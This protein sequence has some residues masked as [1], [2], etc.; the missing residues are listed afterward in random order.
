ME[1]HYCRQK[2]EKEY[3][4]LI[5]TSFKN[6]YKIFKQYISDNGIPSNET[7]SY[8]TF[9]KITHSL[10]IRLYEPKKDQC[11]LCFSF[12]NNN[13]T[14]EI[15]GSHIENKNKARKEKDDDKKRAERNEINAFTLDVQA[16]ELVPFKK[17]RAS[18]FKQKLD[19][20]QFTIYNLKNSEVYCYLWH[21]GEGRMESNVFASCIS[22]FLES[23]VDLKIPT[24]F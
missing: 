2:T 18:Y 12:K 11:D 8:L 10:N 24:S 4:D 20:H 9:L 3:L 7:T 16:V 17:A 14:R 22:N 6:V 13:T 19:V 21:E 5:Y 15:Y 23:Y 1:I